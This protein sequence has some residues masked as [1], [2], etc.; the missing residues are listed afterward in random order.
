[1][2]WY[3]ALREV[4]VMRVRRR[5]CRLGGYGIQG[6][7]DDGQVHGTLFREHVECVER[8]EGVEGLEGGEEN[9]AIIGGTWTGRGQCVLDDIGVVCK[10]V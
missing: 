1:V 4:R 3:Y 9:D 2:G 10:P 7:C 8:T 5:I 6:G